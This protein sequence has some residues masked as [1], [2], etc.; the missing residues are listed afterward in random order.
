LFERSFR[1]N[2]LRAGL[3]AALRNMGHLATNRAEKINYIDLA[4]QVR[5]TT[6]L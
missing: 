3:E 6:L 5:P 4:N 2:A 1:V